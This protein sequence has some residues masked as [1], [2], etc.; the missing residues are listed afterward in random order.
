MKRIYHNHNLW[1]DFKAGLFRPV[2]KSE[3]E[4]YIR[5][6]CSLLKNPD[7][8]Y[9]SMMAVIN[10]WVYASDFNLTNPSRN[11][12]AFLGQ[13]ACCYEFRVPESLTMIA[14]NRLTESQQIDANLVADIVINEWHE[15]K[16]K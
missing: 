10:T 8:L 3:Q 16:I 1:E 2:K 13:A 12:Q 14:W 11:V 6:S 15:R 5:L 7:A 9:R 4:V